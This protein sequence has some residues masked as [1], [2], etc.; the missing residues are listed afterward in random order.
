MIK[1][2][3]FVVSLKR[4]QVVAVNRLSGSKMKFPFE[5]RRRNFKVSDD[6]VTPLPSKECLLF[7]A[8]ITGGTAEFLKV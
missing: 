4:G 3:S 6:G 1:K 7:V 2:S 5:Q 8:K